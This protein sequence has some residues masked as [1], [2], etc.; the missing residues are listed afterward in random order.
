MELLGARNW[1]CPKWLDRILPHIDVE[2]HD[3]PAPP[4]L[5]D[6]REDERVG[7]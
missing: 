3:Q 6:F 5:R 4:D 1:W 2:G 7:V